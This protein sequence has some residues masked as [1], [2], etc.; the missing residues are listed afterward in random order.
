[1]EFITDYWYIIIAIAAIA[2]VIG[3]ATYRFVKLP[4]S[5]QLQKVREWLLYAVT[6][7]EA[8]LGGGTGQL[9]LRYVYNLFATK[10][11]WLVKMVSFE[12]FSG[13]VDDALDDMRAMLEKNSAVKTLVEEGAVK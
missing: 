4:T 10:F 6:E 1:M 3:A 12:T 9:K 8:A 13:L 11:P 5:E 2:G 7:A